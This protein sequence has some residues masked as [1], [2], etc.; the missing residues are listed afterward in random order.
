M[1]KKLASSVGE[2]K[3]PSALAALFVAIEVAL[4]VAIPYLMSF[5]VDEGISKNNIRN[6]IIFGCVMIACAALSLFFGVLSARLAAK[7]SAGFAKNIRARV[8]GKVQDFSFY[9]VDKFSTGSL[10][11]RLTTD[12]NFVQF[13]YMLVIRVA[14]RAPLMLTVSIIMA[15]TLNAKLAVIFVAAIPI[16]AIAMIILIKFGFPLFEKMFKKFDEMNS[17]VQENLIAIRVVKS[18]VRENHETEE[19]RKASAAVQRAQ[20]KAEKVVVFGLP[21]F[22]F[23][24]YA[25]LLAIL[26]FG[27]N[28]VI[29]RTM[30]EGQ[31]SSFIGYVQQ[32]LMS[33]ML[34][35]MILINLVISKASI[36]RIVE[37]LDEAPDISDEHADPSLK[38]AEGSVEFKDVCF[39]YNK[40]DNYVLNDINFKINAGET[41]G[42][43]GGT[44][45]AKTSLVQ[46][47]PRLYDV[48]KGEILVGGKPVDKY[49]L[50]N[51]RDAVAVVLQKNVLFSGTIK[52]NLKWG[53]ENAS[54]EE[55]AEACRIAQADAFIRSF[56][57]GYDTY[58][59]QGGVNV[60]GGQ[61]QR[62]CIAR[63][64]LKRP[65]IMI[66]DDSTSAVD[67]AT[68]A[69]IREGLRTKLK[70][71]T[72]IIIAQR[73][74]TVKE[75]DKIIVMNDGRIDA[76]GRHEEMLATNTIYREVYESQQKGVE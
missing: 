62:L 63:A 32:I 44:G 33:L 42:I 46:L 38:V 4:E 37:V 49:T 21:L 6:V 17:K 74:N 9:N 41:V 15:F 45:S 22:M 59:G 11:T 52:E 68:D 73:I 60:S 18:F 3:R 54:D 30:T 36:K 47:I 20:L 50:R 34:I 8:F 5:I 64:L 27:G 56:P 26:W 7:G 71:M 72:V 75:A 28:L 53:D 19:F 67:T 29:S 40:S 70:G 14:V 13:A 16:L 43:I 55:I 69:K 57:D 39:S 25:C 58:L 12:V 35:G 61:K 48:Q 1:I 24:I 31:L 76:I 10:I 23:C 66:L 51:L 2:Y 65:K